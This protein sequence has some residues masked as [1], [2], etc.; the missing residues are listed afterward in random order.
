MPQDIDSRPGDPP[1]DPSSRLWWAVPA[2]GT[3]LLIL[4][5]LIFGGNSEKVDYGTSYD[6]SSGGS[7]AAFLLLEDLGYPVERSRRPTGGNIRWVLFPGETT[8]KDAT[9]LDD[10]I[11]RGGIVLLALNDEEFAK[12]LGLNATVRGGNPKAT[13]E[14]PFFKL[15]HFR[16]KGKTILAEAPEVSEL[17]AGTLEVKGPSGGRAWGRIGGESLVSIYTHGRGQIWLLNRPDVFDNA[18]LREAD[19]AVL[20]CRLAEAMLAERL[21]GRLVFDEYCH[22]L[23]DR[24]SVVD[25]LLRP[26]VLGITLEA[27]VLTALVLWHSGIRFGPLKPAPPP[28]RRSKEEFLDAMAELLARNGDRAEAFRTVRDAVLRKLETNLG[29]PAGASVEE[30]VKE[31]VRRRGVAPEPLLRILSADKPPGGSSADAF[32]RAL[33]QLET[34]AHECFPTRTR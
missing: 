25:L 32:L 10:W 15:P 24:P 1:A 3:L 16:E 7:R 6:A 14:S 5:G 29:L 23:R 30:T 9:S 13:K 33:Q 26:P 17:S 18:N 19:N 27:L 34:A 4:F 31:A 22:G 11:R 21:N 12:Q 20:A 2:I 28:A 8:A